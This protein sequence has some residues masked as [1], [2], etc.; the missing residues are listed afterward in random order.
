MA[1][2]L[3]EHPLGD[4]QVACERSERLAVARSD[5]HQPGIRKLGDG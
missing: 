4:A 1:V 2:K 3:T 5:D